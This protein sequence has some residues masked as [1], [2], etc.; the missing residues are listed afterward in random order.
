[1]ASLLSTESL[2]RASARR[3]WVIIGIWVLALAVF[4]GL[5]ATLLSDALT[6]EFY[7]TNDADSVVGDK[8]VEERLSGPPK[9][10]DIVIIRSDTLTVDD[11]AFRQ[12]VESVYGTIVGFGDQVIESAV[13]NYMLPDES[14]VSAD[15]RT[16]II[17]FTYAIDVATAGENVADVRDAVI[18]AADERFEVVQTGQATIFDDFATISQE[19]AE[20]GESIAIPI[21]LLIL[22][23]VFGAVVAAL[24]PII[25]AG[26]SIAIAT[27]I[28][29]LVGLTYEF[30]LFVTTI[31]TMIGLAVGIDYSL[32][33]VYRYRDERRGGLEKMDA[34]A[35]AGAI[36]SRAVFFSG[37]TVMLALTG[38]LLVPMDVFN[39]LGAGA[40]FVVS[41]SVLASLTL[42]PAVLG[43]LGDKINKLS[44]PVIGRAQE[45][46]DEQRGGGFWDTVARGVMKQ[47]VVS[48]L[49]SAGLLIAAAIPVFDLNYGFSEVESFPDKFDSKKGFI[50][51]SQEFP[52]L[53]TN[54]V[55]VVIDGAIDDR[56]VQDALESLMAGMEADGSFG[57]TQL[58][59]NGAQDLAVV[60]AAI[61]GGDAAS[62]AAIDAV[63]RLRDDY[64]PDIFGSLSATEVLVA[65]DTAFNIDFFVVARDYAPIVFGFV[66]TM[67]FILLTVVFRS[68]V[69][70]LKSIL[71]NL[72]SVGAAYGLIVLVFQK[73]VGNEFF[74][75]QQISTVE[76]FI[77]LFLF[78]ILFGLSMDYQIF[79][80]SRIRERFD[81]T[82]DNA[83]SV[84][85]GIRTSGRLITGAALIMVVVF[86]GFASGELVPIQQMGF[87][88]GVAILLDA[89]IVRMVL[90]PSV[91]KLLGDWNWYLPRWLN[92]LP[93]L[94]VEAEEPQPRPASA[95]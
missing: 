7:L 33:I 53:L 52:D 25:I 42:L 76:A 11:T 34:I 66:L 56:G 19:D 54:Q 21:A 28:V 1:M 17:P 31:I 55:R 68:I 45:R 41:V 71:L 26:V 75:F 39:S 49:L 72:L 18:A 14:L 64:V 65:G 20:K 74:G 87:G 91:M 6:T 70:A 60:S 86:A 43:L 44:I 36:A 58:E 82:H 12:K 30:N 92:W 2:A 47:P 51:V 13:H 32:F 84:A 50:I 9:Y 35:R 94:R 77:P 95:D 59:V 4:I 40:I 3:P 93:D 15:R 16:T 22:I 61:L 88:L 8:L 73:G 5:S 79:L 48:L 62:A 29:A 27:G 38:M 24:V 83:G 46:F 23:A 57:R 89:T 37:V 63:L 78:S 90:V 67:S 80:L 85:F 81:Q 10:S 69:V